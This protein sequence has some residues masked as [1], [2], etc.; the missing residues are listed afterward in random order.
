[1]K[2]IRREGW[3]VPIILMTAYADVSLAVQ[4]MKEGASDFLVKPIDL[5]HLNL[6]LGKTLE[7]ARLQKKIDLLQQEI[8]ETRPGSGII[9]RSKEML[10]IIDMAKRLAA[11]DSTTVLI[12]GE[13][14]TGKEL[15][16]RYIC[17]QSS[18]AGEPFIRIN[19]GAIPKDLAESEIFGYERGAFTGASDRMKQGKFEL[20]HGGTILLDEIGELS[21]DMQVKLLRV[22]EE[23]RFFRL[24]GTKEIIVDVRILAATNRDIAR[25]VEAGRFR[26]DLFYRLNVAS[27]KIPPLRDRR[28]DIGIMVQVFLEEYCRK[29]NKP[30]PKLSPEVLLLLENNRWK[31]NVRELRNAIERVVLLNDG[32]LLKAE[33][34]IFLNIPASG[35]TAP[36]AP[37]QFANN[38]ILEV[39]DAGVPINRVMKD[40]IL[41]TL[42]ITNG[43]QVRAAKVLGLSRSKLRYRISQLGIEGERGYRTADNPELPAGPTISGRQLL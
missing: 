27:I 43:N 3:Q 37:E 23:Q 25:E 13:S 34:F 1:M 29:F 32:D 28:E 30:V 41:K 40:L 5:D 22:L 8:N 17:E 24:G 16:A 20:A 2:L 10:A 6:L 39:P 18:R 14:G 9:C 36:A 31:G 12:E 15:I 35:K 7:H 4:A 42:A 21:T 19:C 26:E 11:S 33:N 38:Y